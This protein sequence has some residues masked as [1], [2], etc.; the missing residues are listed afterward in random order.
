MLDFKCEQR[1]NVILDVSI[2]MNL[3]KFC[4]ALVTEE[5]TNK[6][7]ILIFATHCITMYYIK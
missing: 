2:L 6:I 5:M 7:N 4:L 1:F 3:N